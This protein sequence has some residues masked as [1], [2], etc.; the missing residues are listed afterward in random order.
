MLGPRE[1]RS[2]GLVRDLFASLSTMLG[3]LL[4]GVDV[5]FV[6]TQC[7]EDIAASGWLLVEGSE[8]WTSVL[9]WFGEVKDVVLNGE[10]D[11]EEDVV[12]GHNSRMIRYEDRGWADLLSVKVVKD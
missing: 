10:E 2:H 3:C 7:D 11:E 1:E 6:T 5:V 12:V 8:L 4:A 9:C